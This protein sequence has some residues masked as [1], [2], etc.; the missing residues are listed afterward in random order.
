MH[1]L[2]ASDQDAQFP[3]LAACNDIHTAMLKVINLL[4]TDLPEMTKN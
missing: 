2:Q 4:H 1:I 3:L